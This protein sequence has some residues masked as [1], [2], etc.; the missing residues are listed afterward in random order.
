MTENW[1]SSSDHVLLAQ[2]QMMTAK[3]GDSFYATEPGATAQLQ[4]RKAFLEQALHDL[5]ALPGVSAAGVTNVMPLSGD[6]GVQSLVRP[7]HPLPESLLPMANQR[8]VSPD[9]FQ[10]MQIPIVAGRGFTEQDMAHPRV[11]IIS[12]KAAKTAWPDVNPLGH[13]LERWGQQ[14]TIIGIAA[15]ARI[16]DLRRDVAVFYLPIAAAPT[17]TP[18]FIIRSSVPAATLTSVVRQALWSIDPLLGIPSVTPMA[19]QVSGSLARERLQTALFSGFGAAALLLAALGVYGVLAYS[20]SLRGREFGIRMAL[21]SPRAA[22]SQ[23]VLRDAVWPVFAGLTAGLAVA[24][25]AGRWAQSLLYQTAARDPVALGG[26][27]L[28]LLA[29]AGVAAMVPALRAADTEPI[30]VLREN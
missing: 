7:D 20:V 9:Y 11:A 17:R 27:V 12:A 3:Y 2:V 6:E 25:F 1:Q 4:H 22:L 15:D 18:V 19:E 28:L 13:T 8:L 16:N 23:L 24:L 29:A 5:Q 14:F 10:A 21:G 26:S 30:R